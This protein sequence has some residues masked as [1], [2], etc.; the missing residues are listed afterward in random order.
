MKYLDFMQPFDG[1]QKPPS[2][3]EQ[4]R[5]T[6]LFAG[7]TRA[8][9]ATFPNDVRYLNEAVLGTRMPR[10]HLYPATDT[11]LKCAE[12]M[13]LRVSH[14]HSNSYVRLLLPQEDDSSRI[15]SYS[16]REK[17]YVHRYDSD[18]TAESR[19]LDEGVRR[20]NVQ[21]WTNERLA[22]QALERELGVNNYPVSHEEIIGLGAL[23]L[24]MAP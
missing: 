16:A 23:L 3:E 2:L 13:R 12:V 15:I 7:I 19:L 6:E 11:A 5:A 1:K 9:L 8:A 14:A 21:R 4:A 18:E 20:Q 10:L 22:N 24:S 17:E